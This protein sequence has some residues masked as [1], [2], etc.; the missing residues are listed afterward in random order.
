[1]QIQVR[2]GD[3]AA[4]N[5]EAI[6]LGIFKGVR[7]PGGAAGVVDRALH[8]ALTE[9]LEEGDFEGTKGET[10]LL[11]TQGK[12]PAKRVLLVG[13][14]EREAF[15]LEVVREV[16]AKAAQAAGK[17]KELTT[18]VHGA[19]MG[20]LA[21]E[22]AAQAVVEGTLLG[23]Y[24]FQKYRRPEEAENKL[25]NLQIVEFDS[26]K[27]EAVKA[28]AERGR[29]IAESVCFAR[30]LANEPGVSLPPRTLAERARTLAQEFAL[31]CQ[32][33]T[34]KELEAEGMAGILGVAR[35]S[36]EPPRLIVLQH[37]PQ[38]KAESPTVLV[39]KGVTFDSGGIS[40]KPRE[41]M[42]AMKYDMSGA[43]AV[44]GAMRAVALLKLP[45]HVVG[46]VPAVENLPSGKALKPGD[47]LRY[48]NGKTV[49]V[50][51]TDAE[52]RLIL[53]DALLYA[54]R[55]KPRA[56]IDLAT[57]T[58]A[59]VVALGKEAAGLFCN[60]SEL[61]EKLQRASQRSGE[62]LWELPLY[63]E[64][65]RLLKSEVADIGNS[66]LARGSTPQ[67][68]AS[69]GAVFL[70][71]FVTYP[72]AHLDIAG[73]ANDMETRVYCPKGATGF[74]VRLL[75]EFLLNEALQPNV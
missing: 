67:A 14:G 21:A 64:Y 15:H 17:F 48:S 26:G 29:L 34:E 58:G 19:G 2:S 49:E 18:L 12:I 28:G 42:E 24:R 44:L 69:A 6:C 74:G 33:L 47:I 45:L 4:V 75:M 20:G 1:M 3:I 66:V 63:E 36:E 50:T 70:K 31:E 37:R 55:F 54:E 11:R 8:G 52:G 7:S 71:E 40:I 53:A 22:E 56:V 72:W 23:S 51:N 73:T 41:G 27:I 35:G 38:K 46:L 25:E 59:C 13:L 61:L 39:G 5:T 10:L 62:R 32:V 68:G 60:D 9:L 57:L 43:A 16:S 65:K 30:D